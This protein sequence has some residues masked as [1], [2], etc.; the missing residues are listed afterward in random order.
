MSKEYLAGCALSSSS[1][2]QP[3]H[4]VRRHGRIGV[5]VSGRV[6]RRLVTAGSDVE[7]VGSFL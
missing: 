5:A 7:M 4:Q 6:Q 3:A 2:P 1:L